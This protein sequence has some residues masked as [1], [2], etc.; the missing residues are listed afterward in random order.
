MK[1]TY[2]LSDGCCFELPRNADCDTHNMFVRLLQCWQ[3]DLIWPCCTSWFLLLSS[4]WSGCTSPNSH[5]MFTA[6]PTSL[7][8]LAIPAKHAEMPVDSP[9]LKPD[10]VIWWISQAWFKAIK[11]M[12]ATRS[13]NQ[14][15]FTG[16]CSVPDSQRRKSRLLQPWLM[17]PKLWLLNPANSMSNSI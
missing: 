14:S 12:I 15:S 9:F 10:G 1:Q 8:D 3:T 4:C 17:Q 6:R 7:F 11:L 13:T 16:W 5:S 2:F